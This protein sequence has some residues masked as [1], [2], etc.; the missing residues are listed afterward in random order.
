MLAITLRRLRRGWRI[1]RDKKD[2]D[3]DELIPYKNKYNLREIRDRGIAWWKETGENYDLKIATKRFLGAVH[4]IVD[5]AVS[6]GVDK[7]I[8]PMVFSTIYCVIYFGV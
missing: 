3:R 1:G 2:V 6:L 4:N 7:I 5:R 8:F